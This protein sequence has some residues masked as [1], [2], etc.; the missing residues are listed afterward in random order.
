MPVAAT[1]TLEVFAA[2]RAQSD[3][4]NARQMAAPIIQVSRHVWLRTGGSSRRGHP[5]PAAQVRKVQQVLSKS[6]RAC[7][8][9]QQWAVYAGVEGC[10]KARG[11]VGQVGVR[12]WSSA[13]RHLPGTKSKL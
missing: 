11:G 1:V 13:M 8:R 7:K 9:A 6:A 10:L 3:V 4:Q 5:S 2:R 12:D